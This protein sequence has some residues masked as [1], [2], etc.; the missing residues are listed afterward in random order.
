MRKGPRSASTNA[1]SAARRTRAHVG[2][3]NDKKGA[4]TTTVSHDALFKETFSRVEH[5]RAILRDALPEP[6]SRLVAWTTL[7]REPGSFV[8]ERLRQQ[9]TD[10]LFTA[11]LKE[12]DAYFYLLF[13][14]QSTSDR[15]MLLRL[16]EY[17]AR[18][19]RAH[20][21]SKPSALGLPLIV[22][23]VLHHSDEGWTSA[24]AFADLLSLDDE[25]REAARPFIPDFRIVLDDLSHVTD[26]ELRG[27]AVTALGKVVLACLRHARDMRTLFEHLRDWSEVLQDVQ[28][29]PHGLRAMELVLSYM[30]QA[31]PDLAPDQTRALIRHV[32][33]PKVTENMLSLWDKII[34]Q[35]RQ[36]GLQE[37]RAEVVLKQLKLKF[38]K[39][40]AGTT[41]RVRN[42]SNEELDRW[43]ERVLTAS[44]LAEVLEG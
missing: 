25:A 10:L 11:K 38:R 40:P 36:E 19:W 31:A 41:A 30:F 37:G 5:A 8:D 24:T 33:A 2:A 4:R 22:P 9:H 3:A 27:R 6:L 29:A 20:V 13:E 18:I 32:T 15:W 12:R 42:A 14:H 17:M 26:E 39:L 16:L 44:T 43:T 34:E 28:S 21:T 23:V 7:R 1:P 35:G